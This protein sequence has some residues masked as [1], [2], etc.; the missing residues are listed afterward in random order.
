MSGANPHNVS[1]EAGSRQPLFYRT[2]SADG[3]SARVGPA[4]VLAEL[5]PFCLSCE[6]RRPYGTDTT[7]RASLPASKP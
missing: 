6:L 3:C 4:M 5:S 2:C 1:W 7:R